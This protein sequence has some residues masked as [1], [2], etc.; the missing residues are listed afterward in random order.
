MSHLQATIEEIKEESKQ[1]SAEIGEILCILKDLKQESKEKNSVHS[2]RKATVH[3][4]KKFIGKSKSM[5]KSSWLRTLATL[6]TA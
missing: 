1:A 2:A 4:L 3:N 5:L 6:I